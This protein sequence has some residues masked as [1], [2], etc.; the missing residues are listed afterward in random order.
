MSIIAGG[1][2]MNIKLALKHDII[3]VETILLEL[4]DL[5]PSIHT[6]IAYSDI[7]QFMRSGKHLINGTHFLSLVNH[8]VYKMVYLLRSLPLTEAPMEVF[9]GI[10]DNASMKQRIEW[11]KKQFTH[12]NDTTTFQKV[13]VISGILSEENITLDLL[14][15]FFSANNT[16]SQDITRYL[17][18]H[19]SISNIIFD[20]DL[21]DIMLELMYNNT[22]YVD[23]FKSWYGKIIT[24]MRTIEHL[25]PS[26][27]VIL[28]PDYRGVVL[29]LL[30]FIMPYIS[31]IKELL[32]WFSPLPDLQ[33]L[34]ENTSTTN[35]LIDRIL[36]LPTLE[37]QGYILGLPLHR[38]NIT[39]I[40]VINKLIE[41]NQLGEEK[42]IK[43][44][45]EESKNYFQ[46]L[47][48]IDNASTLHDE[49]L[50]TGDSVFGYSPFDIVPYTTVGGMYL[51]VRDEAEVIRKKNKDRYNGQLSSVFLS[52][53]VHRQHLA[54][55]YD[56]GRSQ[57]LQAHFDRLKNRIK[58]ER[59]VHV[60]TGKRNEFDG[61][62]TDI[63]FSDGSAIVDLS[64]SRPVFQQL[65][66]IIDD[67][68]YSF[69]PASTV[70]TTTNQIFNVLQEYL[71]GG[72]I[73]STENTRR[74]GRP[75]GSTRPS[76]G[77]SGSG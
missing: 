70:S 36:S 58:K 30:E 7:C 65:L 15:L 31:E 3:N 46:L 64:F 10:D 5:R 60:E 51:Y 74:T 2:K 33:L 20:Y 44:I 48:R 41:L 47:Q 11:S 43:K 40:T 1:S 28:R 69:Q 18:I 72:N 37:E 50:L 59:A 38:V 12:S 6:I 21:C 4:L 13:L 76:G 42:Y 56:L 27:S 9:R 73:T 75:N 16:T 14:P 66:N 19:E 77:S 26:Y 39:P 45:E 25:H 23:V 22:E 29:K 52:E 34:L 57:P 68:S 61:A 53:I 71:N 55:K 49:D 54:E 63:T 67:P 8:P 32:N 35:T 17:I 24:R 62:T